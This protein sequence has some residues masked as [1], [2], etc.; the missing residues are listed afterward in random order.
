M[1]VYFIV[2]LRPDNIKLKEASPRMGHL[3]ADFL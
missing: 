3:I 1:R 2:G